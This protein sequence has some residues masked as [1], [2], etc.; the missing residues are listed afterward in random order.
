MSEEERTKSEEMSK[1]VMREG[2]RGERLLK[3]RFYR[4]L[5]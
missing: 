3:K 5:S 4:I 2:G 1:R